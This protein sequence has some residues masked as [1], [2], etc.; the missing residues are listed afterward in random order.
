MKKGK[1][2]VLDCDVKE[3]E[4]VKPMEKKVNLFKV[5]SSYL[6]VYFFRG[7]YV[8]ISL[9]IEQFPSATSQERLYD[10]ATWTQKLLFSNSNFSRQKHHGNAQA[11]NKTTIAI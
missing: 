7:Q 11:G 4:F 6:Y 10:L 5:Q 9:E 3:A 2:S 1:V 8:S